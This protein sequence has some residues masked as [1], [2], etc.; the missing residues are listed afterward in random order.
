[1]ELKKDFPDA[2]MV[3]LKSPEINWVRSDQPKGM[4]HNVVGLVWWLDFLQMS[5]QYDRKRKR[6]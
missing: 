5:E 1:M 2:K 4:W 3:E 6:K